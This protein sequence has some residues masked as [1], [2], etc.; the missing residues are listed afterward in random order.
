MASITYTSLDCSFGVTCYG[1]R[2]HTAHSFYIDGDPSVAVKPSGGHYGDPLITD[3]NGTLSF[4]FFWYAD[5]PRTASDREEAA[6]MLANITGTKYATI[7]S[8]DGLSTA[9]GSISISADVTED[10]IYQQ[11][12]APAPTPVVSAPPP[13]QT[14]TGTV[15]GPM[16]YDPEDYWGDGG[17]GSVSVTAFMPNQELR[18]GDLTFGDE[19]VLF[20]VAENTTKP[21]SIISNRVSEQN[22]LTMVTS[23]GIRLTVSDNTPLSLADGSAINSTEALGKELPVM[24]EN[25]YRWEEVVELIPAGRGNVATIYCLDQCYA[26]GDEA[27][28]YIFTHNVAILHHKY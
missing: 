9:Y 12:P 10:V 4:E 7:T 5:V 20:D 11:A 8:A 15:V 2:P 21:G 19:L 23:S 18:A 14:S 26:A 27:G 28:R 3:G 13:P 1:L 25:G 22:L 17:G 16:P 24:D 6:R